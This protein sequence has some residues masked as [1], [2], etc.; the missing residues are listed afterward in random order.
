[1]GVLGP[2]RAGRHVPRGCSPSV[3]PDDE[4]ALPLATFFSSCLTAAPSRLH[5][6]SGSASPHTRACSRPFRKLGQSPRGGKAWLL[7]PD[8]IPGPGLTGGSSGLW[9]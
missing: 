8:F 4:S 7:G 1:M 9:T 5:E 6:T 2:L 3:F